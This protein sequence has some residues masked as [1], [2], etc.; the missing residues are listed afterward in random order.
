MF[1][2]V[3]SKKITPSKA[4]N[5]DLNALY[6]LP[7]F[8]YCVDVNSVCVSCNDKN[9]EAVGIHSLKDFEGA[10]L[11]DLG[12]DSVELVQEIRRRDVDVMATRESR[13]NIDTFINAS[14]QHTTI[15]QT[16][17]PLID[18]DNDVVGLVGMGVVLSQ[19]HHN[20][21]DAITALDGEKTHQLVMSCKSWGRMNRAV[22]GLTQLE[23]EI[24]L[25]FLKGFPAKAIAQNFDLKFRTVE[26]YLSNIRQKMGVSSK[27][28][29]F[30]YCSRYNVIQ[31]L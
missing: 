19:D 21:L 2:K 7:I 3:S 9:L 23:R 27:L 29:L 10:R 1:K 22:A 14:G 26:N 11:E 30:Q 15:L 18:T 12:I 31:Y 4:Y 13:T 6:K 16:K 5:F 20:Q 17:H 8:T 24:L 25:E 28:A